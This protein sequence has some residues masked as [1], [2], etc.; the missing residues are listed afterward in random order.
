MHLSEQQIEKYRTDGFVKGPRV[1]SDEQ[2]AEIRQQM[3]DILAGRTKLPEHLLGDAAIKHNAKGQLSAVKVVNLF[4]HVPF[5]ARLAQNEAVSS[6]A[7]DLMQGPVRLWEDQMIYKPPFDSKTVIGWHRDYTYWDHIGP[8]ELGTCWIAIDD[9]H[10]DNGC[11]HMIPGSHRWQLNYTR[12]DVDSSDPDWLLK[13]PSIPA[14]A[15]LTPIACPVEAGYCHFHHCQTFHT[16]YGNK[17]DNPRRS[18]IMHL[19]P[20]TTRRIGDNWNPRMGDLETVPIG[21]IVQGEQ[22]PELAAVADSRH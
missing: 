10:E 18:Y 5:F 6:L 16:S 19:M 15:D 17:T 12:E 9:A 14:D 21:Q 11:M 4:R 7:H 8:S 3:D 1:L 22:Y 2:L 20:G 13:H